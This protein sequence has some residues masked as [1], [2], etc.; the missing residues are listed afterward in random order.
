MTSSKKL[1]IALAVFALLLLLVVATHR[2]PYTQK[3]DVELPKLGAIAKDAVDKVELSSKGET[4]TFEKR[5]ADW[6]ITK[7]KEYKA[8][9]SFAAT[10]VEKLTDLKLVRLAGENKDKHAAYEV[11]AAGGVTLVAVSKGAQLL[12]LIVGKN[13]S[14]F[15]GTFVRLPDSDKV[16]VTGQTIAGTLKRTLKEWRDKTILGALKV[17]DLKEVRFAN[18]TSS[19]GFLKKDAK[20]QENKE[21]PKDGPDAAK[22]PEAVWEPLQPEPDFK[23]DKGRLDTTLR[24]LAGLQWADIV[25]DAKDLAPYGLDAPTRSISF[26]TGTG[27]TVKVLLGTLDDKAGTAWIKPADSPNV[28]QIRKFQYEK[29]TQEKGYFKGES[30]AKKAAPAPGK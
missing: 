19:Y 13:A 27:E 1:L 2:S 16:Y 28:Y 23:I 20:P 26:V 12:R 17:E 3:T 29:F 30:E 14:D 15:Q 5:G 7:P 4:L 11:D 24:I 6:F 9:S 25:E 21:A 8:D 18:G 10:V 22:A